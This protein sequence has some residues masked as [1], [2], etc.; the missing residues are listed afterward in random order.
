MEEVEEKS[1][2]QEV[3]PQETA[4]EEPAQEVQKESQPV[5]EDRQERNWKAFRERQKELERELK[6]QREMNERLMQMTSQINSQPKEIDEFDQISDDEFIPKGKVK[7]L[8]KKQA[9]KIAQDI[10]QQEVEKTLKSRDQANFMNNLRQQYSDFDEVVNTESLSFLEEQEPELANMIADL[11]DPYKIGVQSY[12]YLKA[13]NVSSKVPAARRAKEVEKKIEQ[14][15]K[16]VQ[17]PQAY[18]KRPMAQAFKMTD[19]EMKNLYKEMME[20]AGQASFSY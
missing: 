19:S 4:H 14:N 15:A 11:K 2:N 7:E 18:D 8:V 20:Y 10:A 1:A 13:M 16:T 5:V 6:L 3:A 17:T 12:K 9:A